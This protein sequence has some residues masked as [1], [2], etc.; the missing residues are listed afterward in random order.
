MMEVGT[1]LV[2][3]LLLLLLQ[4][5][6]SG[7]EIALVN[8]D[9]MKLRHRAKMGHAGARLVIKQFEKPERLLATTL[10]GTN[11][12]AVTLVTLGTIMTIRYFG[13]GGDVLAFL[14]ITPVMLVF[15]EVV[16]KSVYQQKADELAPIIIYPLRIFSWLFYP[17]IVVFSLIARMVVRLLSGKQ[18]SKNVFVARE[19]INTLLES[20]E[21]APSAGILDRRRIKHAIRFSSFT[22]AEAMLP[23][24]DMVIIDKESD[25]MHSVE[26]MR[27][28]GFNRLPVYDSDVSRI[29][30]ILM[31]TTWDLL[32]PDLANRS[33]EEFFR[34]AYF[35][36]PSQNIEQLLPVLQSRND[37]MAIV[38]DEFG[39]AIG[40]IS[41][42]SILEQ[43]VGEI[44]D[45]DSSLQ[46]HPQCA[47]EELGND[48][49]VVSAHLPIA[50]LN[51]MLNLQIPKTE[52]HT[53]GGLLVNRLQ[54]IPLQ[55]D[56]ITE[57]GFRFIALECDERMVRKIRIQPEV[58]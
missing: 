2:A 36:A 19:K 50:E 7:S 14:L 43:V 38:V 32:D 15:G 55:D 25:L 33:L 13:E 6:F 21:L 35:V 24:S 11:I 47:L 10:V 53:V 28:S 52:Y 27:R 17:L 16:P 31:V 58:Q 5:F 49:Y 40:L 34:P 44:E 41:V 22:A 45:V 23:L 4:G 48:V 9:K 37:H 46:S 30:G 39:S 29:I 51:E 42:E 18:A 3:M 54:R 1:Y 26:V 20:V 57:S 12:S 8:A 56:Y